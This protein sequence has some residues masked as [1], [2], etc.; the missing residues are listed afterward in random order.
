L[1]RE[2]RPAGA[3][4]HLATELGANARPRNLYY[5]SRDFEVRKVSAEFYYRCEGGCPPVSNSSPRS[6]NCA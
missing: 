5:K 3:L 1:A 6:A 2:F 4:Q